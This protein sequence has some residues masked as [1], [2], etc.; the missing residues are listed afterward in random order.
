MLISESVLLVWGYSEPW[1]TSKVNPRDMPQD[2][3]SDLK[4]ETETPKVL[5]GRVA[6]IELVRSERNSPS[7]RSVRGR[8]NG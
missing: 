4:E 2:S 3:R 7:C 8:C 1:K 6:R 5:T